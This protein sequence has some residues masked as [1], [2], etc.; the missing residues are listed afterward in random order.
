MHGKK[1]MLM[2]ENYLTEVVYWIRL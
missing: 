2:E 1:P